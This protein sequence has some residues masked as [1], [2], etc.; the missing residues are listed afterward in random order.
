MTVK[1]F[2]FTLFIF[3]TTCVF[4]QEN[5]QQLPNVLIEDTTLSKN[6][7]YLVDNF[8]TISTHAILTIEEG[9]V[10]KNI[11]NGQV[12]I[13]LKE[14]SKLIAQGSYKAPITAVTANG[15]TASSIIIK[16]SASFDMD[17][18]SGATDKFSY[19]GFKNPTILINPNTIENTKVAVSE[20]DFE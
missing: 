17:A 8:I 11:N 16:P 1:N 7:T 19:D 10:F 6:T 4:S 2:F 3:I 5:M 18:T 15:D 13:I 9:V 12:V 14:Q 20:I